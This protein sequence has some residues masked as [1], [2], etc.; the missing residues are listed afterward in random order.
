MLISEDL[1]EILALADRIAVMHA[2]E[3]VAIL[4]RAEATAERLGC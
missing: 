3:M 4:P 2:G 1:D